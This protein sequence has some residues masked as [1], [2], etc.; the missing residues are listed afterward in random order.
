MARTRTSDLMNAEPNT[1]S[2]GDGHI[3]RGWH[4]DPQGHAAAGSKGGSK[5]FKD[6]GRAYMAHI[7]RKGGEA[8]SRNLEHMAQIGRKGGSAK[9]SD[10]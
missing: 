10:N 2:T 5:I 8:V 4:G 3:G 1:E 7:G 9:R 6:R